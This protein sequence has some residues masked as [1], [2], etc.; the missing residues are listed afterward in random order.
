MFAALKM[1][2][3][4]SPVS[5]P[6]FPPLEYVQEAPLRPLERTKVNLSVFFVAPS[7]FTL[8]E[9]KVFRATLLRSEAKC[10]QK[11]GSRTTE[12]CIPSRANPSFLAFFR[13]IKSA[14][15]LK[16][17]YSPVPKTSNLA[18]FKSNRFSPPS[19]NK[20]VAVF[21]PAG[22]SIPMILPWPKR[23]CLTNIPTL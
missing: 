5:V 16:F 13:K 9:P 10:H 15:D 3:C 18:N 2:L 6:S 23:L 12:A 22:P 14:E 20:T 11:N 1:V 7:N 21:C 19:L 17:D 4:H 8:I